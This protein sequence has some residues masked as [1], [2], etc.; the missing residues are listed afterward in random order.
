[1]MPWGVMDQIAGISQSMVS[2]SEFLF[3]DKKGGIRILVSQI[4]NSE[5]NETDVQSPP[6]A[7][8]K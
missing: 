4:G 5:T 3:H 1:M 6:R 7:S 8:I 2:I